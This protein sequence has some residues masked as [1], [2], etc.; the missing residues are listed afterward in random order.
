MHYGLCEN[1]ELSGL[2]TLGFAS[3]FSSSPDKTL[4]LVFKSSFTILFY[5][6]FRNLVT[7][8]LIEGGWFNR[9]LL[10]GGSKLVCA[11]L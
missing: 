11:N 3:S 9:L 8:S 7:G 5:N 6:Y 2:K 1:G 4:P 10:N